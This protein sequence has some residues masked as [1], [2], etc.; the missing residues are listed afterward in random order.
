MFSKKVSFLA[1]PSIPV[2]LR[3]FPV[4]IRK[5]PMEI[6][7]ILI[8]HRK[9]NVCYIPVRIAK[10]KCRLGKP[11]FLNQL[12]VRFTRLSLDFPRKP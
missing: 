9:G 2:V 1:L 12:G 3:A 5:D 11:F 6:A 4:A 10:Q 7:D 8:A